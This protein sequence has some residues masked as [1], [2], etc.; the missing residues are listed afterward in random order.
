[1]TLGE[2]KSKVFKL[3]EEASTS[4][5]KYTDDTD[6]DKKINDVINQIMLELIRFKKLPAFKQEEVKKD[7]QYIL[8]VKIEDFYQLNKI[9]GVDYL[10]EEN[11]VMFK[12][13]GTAMIHYYRYPKAIDEDTDDDDYEF[14]LSTDLLGAMPYGV[15]ADVLK[16]DVSNQYGQVYANRYRELLQGLD[17]RYAVSSVRIEGGIDF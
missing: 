17:P 11:L 14:E 2:M 13:D 6:L 9:T 1:M 7:E 4:Q 15:A 10:R 3:I 16:S 5:G 12:E 8:D